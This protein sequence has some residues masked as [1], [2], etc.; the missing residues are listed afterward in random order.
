LL[1]SAATLMR[2]RPSAS[3]WSLLPKMRFVQFPWRWMSIVAV[4]CA[5]FLAA[6]I[7]RRRGWLWF[8]LVIV[9]RSVRLFSYAKHLVGPG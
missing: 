7:E 9:F 6:A 1:G 8:V 2:F 4:V 5:C 3:L